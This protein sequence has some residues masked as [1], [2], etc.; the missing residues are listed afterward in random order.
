MSL[1]RFAELLEPAP[2]RAV[3]D[4]VAHPGDDATEDGGID[5]DLD[6]HP[7]AGGPSERVGEPGLLV[8]VEGESGADLGDG[9]CARLRG[10]ADEPVDDAGKV[11]GPAGRYER[12]WPTAVTSNRTPCHER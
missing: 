7:L 3:D 8:G 2:Y 5:D 1:E 12:A 9:L 4:G 6:R 11:V 10:Q